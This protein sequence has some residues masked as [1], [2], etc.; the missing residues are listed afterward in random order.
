MAEYLVHGEDLVT[1]ADAIREKGGTTELLAF[2]DGFVSAVEA[3]ETGEDNMVKYIQ[4]ELTELVDR[5]ITSIGQWFLF[6]RNEVITKVDLPNVQGECNSSAFYDAAGLKTCYLPR[7]S[8]LGS[9]CFFSC[10]KLADTDFSSVE[11]IGQNCF[12]SCT[13]IVRL[14]FPCLTQINGS[15]NFYGCN[16]LKTLILRSST[17]VTLDNV[18]AFNNT[19]IASGTGYIYVPADLVSIYQ[20]DS[21]WSTYADQFRAIEDYPDV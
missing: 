8:A 6:Y 19:P 18:N 10:S 17:M 1:V 4:G 7:A 3:I 11:T 12:Q 21:V 9:S 16:K 14:D 5:K 20:A 2:P 13:S 15:Y